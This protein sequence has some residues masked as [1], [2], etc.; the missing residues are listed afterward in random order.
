[1]LSQIYL[2]INTGKKKK[3]KKKGFIHSLLSADK[4]DQILI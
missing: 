2:D 1:M 4:Q 3:R